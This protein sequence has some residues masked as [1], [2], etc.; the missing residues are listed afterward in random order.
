M[1]LSGLARLWYICF[2]WLFINAIVRYKIH[3][4]LLLIPANFLS[5]PISSVSI[6]CSS[7]FLNVQHSAPYRSTDISYR[8]IFVWII[9]WLSRHIFFSRTKMADA[10]PILCHM[11]FLHDPSFVITAPKYVNSFTCFSFTFSLFMSTSTSFLLITSSLT[12][13]FSVLI[14][15]P[16]FL[17]VLWTAVV[18]T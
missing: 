7:T 9:T 3:F 6:P 12:L 8:V 11:S 4:C 18:M 15:N 1:F 16:S 5:H 2:L 14:F 17:L 13:V 10:L